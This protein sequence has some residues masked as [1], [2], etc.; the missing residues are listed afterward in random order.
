MPIM[1]AVEAKKIFLGSKYFKNIYSC[2]VV[3]VR[4][5][6]ISVIVRFAKYKKSSFLMTYGL[7]EMYN[8]QHTSKTYLKNV[9]Q[10][11]SSK[12]NLQ[13]VEDPLE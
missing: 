5:R 9:P 4:L 11:I 1:H 6:Q 3:W 8:S 2:T 13:V 7:S 12:T 10:P